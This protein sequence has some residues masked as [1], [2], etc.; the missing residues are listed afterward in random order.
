MYGCIVCMYVCAACL[1]LVPAEARKGHSVSWDWS[2][3]VGAL[4]E[5]Q[6]WLILLETTLHIST[7]LCTYTAA[8]KRQRQPHE[9]VGCILDQYFLLSKVPLLPSLI[10]VSYLFL[11][12]ISLL[13]HWKHRLFIS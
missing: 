9:C 7:Q 3:N 10:N 4:E 13:A 2:Y 8:H 5:A 11:Q 6:L 1:C 12:D